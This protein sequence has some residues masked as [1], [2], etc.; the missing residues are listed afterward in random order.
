MTQILLSTT[1]VDVTLNDL[2]LSFTHPVVDQDI[3]P[4]VNPIDI[5][6][7]V[8][9]QTSLDA[10][11]ITLKDDL[12]NTL[13]DIE[14]LDWL[15]SIESRILPVA[16]QAEAQGKIV[17]DKALTPL[18]VVNFIYQ[19]TP[20]SF[21]GGT[22]AT[23]FIVNHTFATATPMVHLIYSESGVLK[24]P[25]AEVVYTSPTQVTVNFAASIPFGDSL[26][27]ILYGA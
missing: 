9:L 26:T 4:L 10:G 20:A 23:S 8:D 18:S 17:N 25:I 2:D 6:K 22:P 11:A 3:L 1:G 27:V 16:S 14:A 7:S 5:L 12:G 13:S 15:L 19:S 21:T 24:I